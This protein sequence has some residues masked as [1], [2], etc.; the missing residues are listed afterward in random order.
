MLTWACRTIAFLPP[1]PAFGNRD[2]HGNCAGGDSD[3][4]EVTAFYLS[5]PLKRNGDGNLG[6][7]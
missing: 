5:E 6:L 7:G 2:C 1:S 4:V 3:R